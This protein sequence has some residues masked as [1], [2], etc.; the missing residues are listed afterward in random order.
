MPIVNYAKITSTSF[1]RA[2]GVDGTI[3]IQY[4]DY[5]GE[6][7]DNSYQA[8][9]VVGAASQGLAAL[10]LIDIPSMAVGA[11]ITVGVADILLGVGSLAN[12]TVKT[13]HVPKRLARVGEQWTIGRTIE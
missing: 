3:D 2:G 4:L 6:E 8:G 9:I 5:N 7:I 13:A 11:L 1:K 10:P 12:G